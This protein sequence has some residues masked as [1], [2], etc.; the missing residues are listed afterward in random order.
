MKTF[1]F[2][3]CL[4]TCLFTAFVARAAEPADVYVTAELLDL[5]EYTNIATVEY[6]VVATLTYVN[7]NVTQTW[8]LNKDNRKEELDV[9]S[10]KQIDVKIEMIHVGGYPNTSLAFGKVKLT[11]CAKRL[12]LE[13]E[14][15]GKS[16]VEIPGPEEPDVTVNKTVNIRKEPDCGPQGCPP[17]VQGPDSQGGG[18]DPQGGGPGQ[19]GMD[20]SNSPCFTCGGSPGSG[21]MTV[22]VPKTGGTVQIGLGTDAAGYSLGL[23]TFHKAS[24]ADGF[25]ASTDFSVRTLVSSTRSFS[26]GGNLVQ[27]ISDKVIVSLAYPMGGDIV[28]SAYD[29]SAKGAALDPLEPDGPFAILGVDPLVTYTFAGLAADTHGAGVSVEKEVTGEAPLTW[30]IRAID[31]AQGRTWRAVSWDG[32]IT[33]GQELVTENPLNSTQWERT[34]EVSKLRNGVLV[35]KVHSA[36]ESGPLGERMVSTTEGE[37]AAVGTTSYAYYDGSAG[38]VI[39][40]KL[41]HVIEP[42]GNWKKYEYDVSGEIF[43]TYRPWKDLPAHPDT[44]TTANSSYSENTGTSSAEYILGQLVSETSVTEYA[45]VTVS[46]PGAGSRNLDGQTRLS[47]TPA[48]GYSWSGNFSADGGESLS[49]SA[50]GTGTYQAPEEEGTWNAGTRTFTVTTGPA[51]RSW[52]GNVYT[53]GSNYVFVANRSARTVTIRVDGRIIHES[54]EVYN[55]T[56]WSAF[57]ETVYTYDALGRLTEVTKDGD[58]ISS[59]V[60]HSD[61]ARTE[62]DGHGIATRYEVSPDGLIATTIRYGTGGAEDIETETAT[63]IN[64]RTTT[65][66]VTMTAGS[67]TRSMTTVSVVDVLGRE[68]SSTDE[69]GRTTTTAYPD[70]LSVTVTSPGGVEEST[71]HYRDGQLKSV[72]SNVASPSYY[73]YDLDDGGNGVILSRVDDH[74]NTPV[75][76]SFRLSDR[77]GNTFTEGRPGPN[78]GVISTT[79]G[80]DEIGRKVSTET[81]G[82]AVERTVYNAFG[83]AYRSGKDL[84]NNGT[85]DESSSEPMTETVTQYVKIGSDWWRE[86]VSKV[87]VENNAGTTYEMKY[88][89]RLGLGA[90]GETM[91]VDHFGNT[92]ATTV[93]VNRGTQTVT[94]TRDSSLSSLNAVEVSVGGRAESRTSHTNPNTITYGPYDDFGQL[95]EMDDPASGTTA[96]TYDSFGQ[97]LTVTDD[98]NAVTTYAYYASGHVHAGARRSVTDATNRTVYY[99]YDALGRQTHIWG[100]TYP[101]RYVYNSYGEQVAMHTYRSFNDTIVTGD[102]PAAFAVAGDVT[103]W[104]YQGETGLLLEKEDAAGNGVT[105]T[106]TN[107]GLPHTRVWARGITATYTHDNLGQLTFTNYSDATPDITRT[108]DR[109]GRPITVSGGPAGTR[110]ISYA[111]NG[112]EEY[113]GGIFDGLSITNNLS[114][115]RPAGQTVTNGSTPLASSTLSYDSKGRVGGASFQSGG[116]TIGTTYGY[117]ATHGRISSVTTGG[118]QTITTAKVW[119]AVGRLQS[120]TTT[121]AGSAVIS[122]RTYERDDV[123]RITRGTLPGG[124]YWAYGYDGKGQVESSVKRLANETAVYGLGTDYAY[125]DIGNSLSRESTANLSGQQPIGSVYTPNSVNQYTAITHSNRRFLLGEAVSDAQV[126]VNGL[127]ASRQGDWFASTVQ[128]GNSTGPAWAPVTVQ[129]AKPGAGVGGSDLTT[130][131]SGGLYLPPATGGL[132]Y[133]LDGNLTS[134]GRWDYTWDAEN[135][136]ITMQTK[137]AAILAGVPIKRVEYAYDGDSR[138]IS[139]D[140]LVWNSG[141]SSFDTDPAASRYVWRDWTLLAEAKGNGSRMVLVRAYSWG[142]DLADSMEQNGNVGNLLAIV[143]RSSGTSVTLLPTYDGN[144]NVIALANGADGSLVA[145]Y[146]YDAFGNQVVSTNHAAQVLPSGNVAKTVDANEWGF[147]TKAVDSATGL[148]YYGHRYYDPVTGRWPSRDPIAEEGGINVYGFIGNDPVNFI[149]MLG[150][151]RKTLTVTGSFKYKDRGAGRDYTENG[152]VY[153]QYWHDEVHES[154]S[155]VYTIEIEC[156][157]R[158]PL[159]KS[160]KGHPEVQFHGGDSVFQRSVMEYNRFTG[161]PSLDK[162]LPLSLIDKLRQKHAGQKF[163]DAHSKQN[164]G[165]WFEEPCITQWG[166]GG[167]FGVVIP[168]P[169]PDLMTDFFR[170]AVR[171]QII[172]NVPFVGS[173]VTSWMQEY[174]DEIQNTP[175]L[176][177]TA[178]FSAL[179]EF[180]C[181]NDQ[182]KL[183]GIQDSKSSDPRLSIKMKL[184]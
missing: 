7:D 164:D 78:S 35:S 175:K 38:P 33:E 125:D 22:P 47:E 168:Q 157:D 155:I 182:L 122:G 170:G 53:S 77:L 145:T 103:T 140:E 49:A 8:I 14:E 39:E 94:T 169:K 163:M 178:A 180:S 152:R 83:E 20:G 3:A 79:H 98:S 61:R 118:S 177:A 165:R 16:S 153:R 116:Q 92:V 135:R 72:V 70:H 1:H 91:E 99:A 146:D 130:S 67:S 90:D 167:Q 74:P 134:D 161:F 15:E 171:T 131:T 154:A 156:R 151:V 149:D 63:T 111:G 121:G 48:G 19:G 109:A 30:S 24:V 25:V 89:E 51:R 95:L 64:G 10:E 82:L 113:D 138:R 76:W 43:R 174:Y 55:G 176:M 60:Y 56:Q 133:D 50:D 166:V 143:D 137:A 159:I 100:D 105:Y 88:A 71:T 183:R 181:K 6:E 29:I 5:T 69:R 59:T 128:A 75:R 141:T 21:G 32:G 23:I 66:L 4:C 97:L 162:M 139:R 52:E 96:Y 158:Q 45:G 119:N 68:I 108:Y 115:G 148:L 46:V 2:F 13:G 86:T 150:L 81:S 17:G 80:Y 73:T 57:S 58:I 37:G 147:S 127:P 173:K 106:Y 26:S 102:I 54:Q 107:E 31:G 40:G 65:R 85:L 172:K 136:L 34:L 179:V 9:H 93:A 41:R 44:A 36:F 184:E 104:H 123:G 132:T 62:T 124:A 126:K 42:S 84:N 110:T 114:S 144:G 129:V 120:T 18:P 87:W 27:V 117:H 142:L 12:Q 28:V 101:V 160:F 11:T 112:S